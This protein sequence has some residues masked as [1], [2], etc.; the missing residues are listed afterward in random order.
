[1]P[2]DAP[3]SKIQQWMQSVIVDPR[4]DES[5]AADHTRRAAQWVKPTEVLTAYERVVIYRDQYLLRMEEA[6]RADYEGLA[7]FLGERRFQKLV[8]D[9]VQVHP[10]VHYNLNRLSDNLPSFLETWPDLVTSGRRGFCV[11]MARLELAVARVFDAPL[12]DALDASSLWTV[13]S[14]DWD[15]ARLR[16]VP[17][18]QVLALDFPVN[19]Y[20]E[21]VL[22]GEAVTSTRR[23]ACWVA[24]YRQHYAMRRLPLTAAQ[25]RALSS[26]QHGETLFE[27]FTAATKGRGRA[28]P[29]EVPEWFARWV[30]AGLFS[31][32]R[33]E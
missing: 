2:V 33:V 23:R 7:H 28:N 17:A 30:A 26:L 16:P 1:M 13:P 15:R 27:A 10:S 31:A 9:Y 5:V 11:D 25:Y 24:V 22:T 29:A 18:L 32:L 14:D 19:D 4:G 12:A 8:A 6:L 21:A 20:L 3:L